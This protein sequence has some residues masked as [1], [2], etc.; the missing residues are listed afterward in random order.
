MDW[1]LPLVSAASLSLAAAPA[2][3]YARN[4]SVFRV[5]AAPEPTD[6]PLSVLIPARNESANIEACVRSVLA[7]AEGVEV[8]VVVQDDASEDDTAAIVERLATEDPRVRLVA[9][10]PLP[11]GWNG[12][13]HA[14]Q[15]LAEAA[16]NDVFL[17]IDADVRLEPDALSRLLAERRRT[18]ADLLSGFP[19]QVTVTPLERMLLPLIH[20]VLLGFLS[21]RAMRGSNE[22]GFAAGCGQLFLT[23][24]E[25]YEAAGGHAAVR[26]SRH[27][28]VTL[29]RAY[30]RAGRTTDLFDA[31][32]LAV[33]RMYDGAGAVWKGLAKNATEGVAKPALIVPVTIVLVL[34]QVLPP[35]LLA[36]AVA[37]GATVATILAGAA[38]L[39]A[40]LPRLDAALRFRQPIDGAL[41]HP[42]SVL[43]FLV[44]QWEALLRER[45]GKP[46]AWRGRG[47][48]ATP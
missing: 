3:F 17:W 35:V 1:Q 38:T 11:A 21:L 9:G 28:G 29:P 5:A 14:C 26:A 18:G 47:A 40:Y 24:R 15:R 12:K 32:D 7:A 34:G 36:M 20:F 2:Y 25:A 43:L 13:Q 33:C 48:A 27:D 46:V 16:S 44:I 42:V 30:R 39:L 22:P 10:V 41:L 19:R 45:I 37:R 31:T 4:R 8:E 6:T 23:G